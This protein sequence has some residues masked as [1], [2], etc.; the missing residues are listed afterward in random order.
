MRLEKKARGPIRAI[1]RYLETCGLEMND[2]ARDKLEI[3][4]G[5]AEK[6]A[7]NVVPFKASRKTGIDG[8]IDA[9]T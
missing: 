3:V 1:L 8:V 7:S 2:K 5:L 4:L 9:A 6:I